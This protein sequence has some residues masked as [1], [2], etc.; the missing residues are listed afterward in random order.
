[1][2][3][4]VSELLLKEIFTYLLYIGKLLDLSDN[5]LSGEVPN[6]STCTELRDIDLS[7]NELSGVFPA[8]IFS[9]V[10]L[11]MLNLQNNQLKG[12]IPISVKS[13]Q[14]WEI[15]WG[16]II[17]NNAFTFDVDLIPAPVFEVN[18]IDGN[19]ISSSNLYSSNEYTILY[20]FSLY[21][22]IENLEKN[23]IPQLKQMYSLYA[24]NGISII[25]YCHEYSGTRS[26]FYNHQMNNDISWPLVYWTSDNSILGINENNSAGLTI[27]HG[28]NSWYPYNSVPTFIVVDNNGNVTISHLF[29][30]MLEEGE[31]IAIRIMIGMDI[32]LD[33]LYN[34]F[35]YKLPIKKSKNKKL[36]ID[37]LGVDL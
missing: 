24:D 37:E 22:G 20:Q 12:N 10:N 18:D 15:G 5:E 35:A 21:F 11:N 30:S 1:M 16:W 17:T 36:L 3:K 9:M 4:N 14:F 6:F 32:D 26:E 23:I 8:D 34:E 19:R 13:K 29:S 27:G 33:D 25:G 31:G 2:S 7:N 28:Y